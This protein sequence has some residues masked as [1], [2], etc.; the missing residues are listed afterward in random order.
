MYYLQDEFER[1]LKM[2]EESI[3]KALEE[4][5]S[6]TIERGLPPDPSSWSGPRVVIAGVISAASKNARPKPKSSSGLINP[7]SLVW[8]I[9]YKG[10]PTDCNTA[11]SAYRVA[12]NDAKQQDTRDDH[13]DPSKLEVACIDLGVCNGDTSSQDLSDAEKTCS[14]LSS[15]LAWN[16]T[17]LDYSSNFNTR[18]NSSCVNPGQPGFDPNVESTTKSIEGIVGLTSALLTL[19]IFSMVGSI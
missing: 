5:A 14:S 10:N 4:P 18:F 15:F 17:V 9:S 7:K 11:Y 12:F 2:K 6:A 3:K 19:S 1:L 13:W 16:A 8:P